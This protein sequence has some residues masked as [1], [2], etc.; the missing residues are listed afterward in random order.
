M[1]HVA[2]TKSN[3][4][5]L[6]MTE[7]QT[8][9]MPLYTIYTILIYDNTVLGSRMTAITVNSVNKEVERSDVT[10][11]PIFTSQLLPFQ[12]GVLK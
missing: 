1:K 10:Y 5:G 8:N 3:I 12:S 6:V 9:Q 11:L 7:L 4:G 2:A